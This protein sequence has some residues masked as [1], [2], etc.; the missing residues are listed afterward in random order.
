MEKNLGNCIFKD[1]LLK[2]MVGMFV[3]VINVNSMKIDDIKFDFKYQLV[4]DYDFF[5]RLIYKNDV[6]YDVC[7]LMKY[8]MYLDFLMVIQKVGWGK[9]FM[10]LY[11][12]LIYNLLSVD[13]I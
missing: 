11:I 6:Y 2:Y 8:W 13:E 5:L 12:D 3:V 1:L 4:E 7:L 9:E 10:C